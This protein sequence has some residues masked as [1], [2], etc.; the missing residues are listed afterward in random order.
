FAQ[1]PIQGVWNTGQEN[2]MIEIKASGDQI[3][4]KVLSSDNSKA[5]IGNVII[6]DVRAER[7]VYKG[8]LYA[9]KRKKWMDATFARKADKLVITVSA[10]WK[11]KVIEWKAGE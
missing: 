9:A 11:T 1:Q 7:G 8:Q 4:G 5:K 10:G 6:K 2:T 3:E